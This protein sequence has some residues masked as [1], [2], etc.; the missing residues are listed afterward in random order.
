[1]TM[2]DGKRIL[3]L[4]PARGGS[5]GIKDKNIVGLCGKPLIAY[6]VEA[7]LKSKYIDRTVI[8]TDSRKIADVALQCSGDVPFIRPAALAEDTSKTI[9]VAMHAV[10]TLSA[11]GDEY[12]V[13]VL[14]QPTQPLRTSRD[15][16]GALETFFANGEN[17]LVSVCEAENHPLLIRTVAEGRL[18]RLLSE[19]STCRRQDMPAYYVVNGCVYINKI[20]EI[21]ESLSFNDNTVPYIMPKERSVDIDEPL[22]IVIAE[23]IMRGY[24]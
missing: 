13:F 20:S 19:S 11:S 9:D 17:G 16:D 1:M 6:S 12:D 14:I 24:E 21:N 22:D 18:K 3:A 8:S 23:G 15:I 10:R 2:Y 7:C 5:K 4:I